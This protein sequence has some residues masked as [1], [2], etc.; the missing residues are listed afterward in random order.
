MYIWHSQ[1]GTGLSTPLLTITR[2]TTRLTLAVRL[3]GH[4]SYDYEL[5]ASCDIEVR[6]ANASLSLFILVTFTYLLNLLIFLLH[7]EIIDS[8]RN[9]KTDE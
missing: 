5:A 9:R 1:E 6:T 3:S 4:I 7:C 8:N 2:S